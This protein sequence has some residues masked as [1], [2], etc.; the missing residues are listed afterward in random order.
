M[1]RKN[2]TINLKSVAES[3]KE[4]VEQAKDDVISTPDEKRVTLTPREI[5][6]ELD[7]D[8]PDGTDYTS[9]LVSKVMDTDGRLAKARVVSSLTRGLSSESLGQEDRFRI[10]ALG[11][12]S[13]QLIEPDEWVL[14]AA[15]EDIELLIHIN[16]IL[17]EHETRYFR[18]NTR[19]SHD[20]K[21]QARIRST[22]T[23]FTETED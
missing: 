5:T 17:L 13:I 4:D 16:N 8:A 7:Y 15:G 9:N 3:A 20:D 12:L 10:E 18:G 21:I 14:N 23:A 22:V 2:S 11:R 19:K 1:G 6:F